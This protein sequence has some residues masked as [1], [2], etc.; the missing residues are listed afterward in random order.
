M[1]EESI[2]V[3][4]L[5]MREVQED[6]INN[7]HPRMEE[8]MIKIEESKDNIREC[9]LQDKHIYEYKGE[10][11]EEEVL[12]VDAATAFCD[13]GEISTALATGVVSSTSENVKPVYKYKAVYGT[14]SE[15]FSRATNYLRCWSELA[16]L[17]YATE[18]DTWVLYDGSFTSINFEMGKWASVMPKEGDI[19]RDFVESELLTDLFVESIKSED[20]DWF[21]V[22]GDRKLNKVIS[23]GKRGISKYYS[24]NVIKDFEMEDTAFLPSD[25][26]ILGTVLQA[27]EYTKP[28]SYE[29]VFVKSHGS[30]TPGYG[31]PGLKSEDRFNSMQNDVETTYKSLQILHFKPWPWSP[32]L[33]IEYNGERCKLDDVLAVIQGQTKT[34]SILEPMALYLADLLAKQT[35]SVMNFYGDINTRRYPKL[36][37]AYRTSKRG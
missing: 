2:P 18:Q 35:Q 14:S 36:F 21:T 15:T 33:K 16:A 12:G 34:R 28:L 27:N 9:L 32:V 31:H 11:S 7:F 10:A 26:F 19:S 20:S 17:K 3:T 29:Q 1:N 6:L 4:T 23:V 22:F 13:Y 24:T 8:L 5:F 37:S 30:G 25:K